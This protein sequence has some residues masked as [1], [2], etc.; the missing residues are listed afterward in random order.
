MMIFSIDLSSKEKLG[1]D[2]PKGF[3]ED[4]YLRKLS[5]DGLK[6]KYPDDEE[7]VMERLNYELNIICENGL[8]AFI[9]VLWDCVSLAKERGIMV[10]PG[11]GTL[12]SSLV[13]YCLG[14]TMVD[15]IANNLIFERFLHSERVEFQEAWIDFDHTRQKEIF[16]YVCEKYKYDSPLLSITESFD[17]EYV[18]I[19]P[20]LYVISETIKKVKEK[21]GKDIDIYSLQYD[22]M[23]VFGCIWNGYIDDISFLERN[24]IRNFFKR[25]R[26]F[27]VEQLAA[28]IWL[29]PAAD[30]MWSRKD[31]YHEYIEARNSKKESVFDIE[32]FKEITHSTYGLLLYQEQIIEVFNRIGGF[33]L[34]Q[35][36]EAR[37]SLGK[38]SMVEIEKNRNAFINGDRK[39]GISGCMAQGISA[40]D[41]VKIYFM[42]VDYSGYAG[43]KSHLLSLATL[44]YQIAWLKHYYPFE[45]GEAFS[46]L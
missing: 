30:N 39:K 26:P 16:N 38:R 15:P 37:K 2:C 21:R 25:M 33:S 20:E 43:N 32:A 24:G 23:D 35:S 46:Y 45:Y 22:D 4:S 29:Y 11:R 12:P 6:N 36:N 1:L 28:G 31:I 8:S 42:M 7:K 10:G 41:G 3:D 17:T 5:I 18:G 9:L 40:E 34:K 44:A 13:S 14:I 19:I 27:S